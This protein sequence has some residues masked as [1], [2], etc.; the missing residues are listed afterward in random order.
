MTSAENDDRIQHRH[1]RGRRL[2]AL[3]G[4]AVHHLGEG[5][6][7]TRTER[8]GGTEETHLRGVKHKGLVAAFGVDENFIDESDRIA[9]PASDF[10]F[11]RH[12][13]KVPGL[14]SAGEM[15]PPAAPF[16]YAY[17]RFRRRW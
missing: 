13:G 16:W 8:E 5:Q 3:L 2:P 4:A 11:G 7:P 17:S 1:C 12:E 15:E 6:S 9:A 10:V 14:G